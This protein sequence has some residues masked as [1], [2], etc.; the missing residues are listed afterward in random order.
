M[1]Y[2]L[3]RISPEFIW[4]LLKRLNQAVPDSWKRQWASAIRRFFEILGYSIVRRDDYYSPVPNIAELKNNLD[5]WYKPSS[6]AGL[7]YDLNAFKESLLH[8]LTKYYNDFLKYPDYY[9][10]ASQGF[11]P[12]F[13]PSDALV[14]YM[15]VREY[16]PRL[17]IEIG[18]G[19]STYYC[20]LAAQ[21]NKE[22]GH[23]LEIKCIE[24]Y[25]YEKLHSI[26]G[27]E[28][29]NTEVQN[30][31]PDFFLE[32]QANDILLID[33]SHTLKIDGDISYLVLEI[34]PILK[35]GVLI[36]FH[37]INFPYNIPYPPEKWIFGQSHDAPSWPVFWTEAMFLQAFLSFNNKFRIIQS[38]ALLSYYD[39]KF[40]LDNVPTYKSRE[41]D[42]GSACSLWLQKG[43]Q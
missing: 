33:S 40:L 14:L 21:D 26:P 9:K 25:P 27:I 3:K 5:R 11:G 19:I 18:S 32:L 15:M 13:T 30:I 16:K 12:G 23:P 24:P 43:G 1:K 42:P 28:I 35:D 29:Y 4:N 2:F 37:D 31:K 38:L 10:I 8:L 36:H 39:E 22:I 20:S 17:Y 41:L 6:L 34:L 7:E